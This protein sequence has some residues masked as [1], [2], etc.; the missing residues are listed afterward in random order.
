[1]YYILVAV[2]NATR[3]YTYILLCADG[4]YYT[5]S[6]KDLEKRLEHHNFHKS[7]ARYT[8]IRRPVTLAY[9]ETFATQREAMLREIAIKRLPKLKKT[10]LI[11]N[12]IK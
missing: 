7:G 4:T 12:Q 9:Y 2:E 3:Y 5:G 10:H 6:T 8:R 1:M 11:Q